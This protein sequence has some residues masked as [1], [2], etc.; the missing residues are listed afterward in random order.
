MVEKPVQPRARIPAAASTTA[1]SSTST[2]KS[3]ISPTIERTR[4]GTGCAAR[5]VRARRNRTRRPRPT[6]RC[7]CRRYWSS[8]RRSAG[9]ARRTWWRCPRRHGRRTASSSAMRI[10]F[11]VYIAIQAVPSDWL[12]WPPVG[13]GAL[14]SK[15]PILSSPRNPPWKMLRPSASLRFTHQVKFSISLWKTRSR[16]AR[17]PWPPRARAVDLVDP[18]RRPGVHRRVDVAERPFIGRQLPVRV[19]VPFAGQQHELVLGEIRVDQRE[20]HAVER[21]VPGGVP[22]V[23]P[24]VRHRDDVGVVE[25]PP[26]GVA[27]VQPRPRAAA[28][29]AGRRAASARMSRW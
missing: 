17:S 8:P 9:N 3:G 22:R 4:S 16:K 25:M 2:A 7:R 26:I 29:A 21:E 14:R 23:F 6:A 1:P 28:A 10:R 27:A 24:L 5:A 13:S 18:P 15:M 11:S 20:G 12:M 19:H